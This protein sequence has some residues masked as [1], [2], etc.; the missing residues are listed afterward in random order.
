MVEIPFFRKFSFPKLDLHFGRPK[1]SFVGIDI[2]TEAAKVVQLRKDQERAVLET[3]GELKTARYFKKTSGA[4]GGFLKFLDQDIADMLKDVLLESNV[5]T[6]QA[7]LGIPSISSFITVID[8][9]L[10][11]REEA[12]D[13]VPFEARR[14]IPI[15]LAEV[16]MDWEVIEE[17]EALKRMKILI[18]VVPNEVVSKYKRI[19]ELTKLDIQGF[20]IESFSLVRSLVGRDRGV[21]A[22][23]HLGAQTTSVT[24]ADNRVVRSS[25]NIGRGSHEVTLSLARSLGIDEERA[26]AMKKEVGLSTKPEEK[27]IVDIMTPVVDKLFGEIERIFAVYNRANIRK[28]ERIILAGGGSSLGGLVDYVSKKIGLETALGNP[29]ALTVYPAFMQPI[30]KDIGPGFGVAAGL[31]LRPITSR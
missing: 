31:A 4:G 1:A 26:E 24:I 11:S 18:A 16:S 30:L 23:V 13:A 21:V 17:D 10:I 6:D 15:P 12:K 19:G 25:T 5:T 22:V 20:E 28:V 29:F 7:I 9:P 2:G 27:E 14:Y 8:L 3:Y